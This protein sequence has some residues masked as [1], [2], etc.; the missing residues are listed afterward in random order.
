MADT[1]SNEK[2]QLGHTEGYGF[3]L[4][5]SAFPPT[6]MHSVLT[7]PMLRDVDLASNQSA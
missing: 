7:M 3:P 6:D 4:P 5:Q 2:A 1:S